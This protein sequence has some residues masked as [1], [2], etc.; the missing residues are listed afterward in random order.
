MTSLLLLTLACGGIEEIV[1]TDDQNFSFSSDIAA[2]SIPVPAQAD[3]PVDW[4]ALT[5]DLLGSA[6]EP[7]ADVGS[8]S[9][10]RFGEL[11]EE[12]VI[13]GINNESLKQSDLTGFVSYTPQGGE[14]DAMLSEFSVSG[15]FVDV[16]KEITVDGGTYL[17]SLE[18]Q[19]GSYMTFTFFDPTADA[20]DATIVVDDESAVL[21]YEADLDA[22]SA[23]VLP[24]AESYILTWS[25]LTTTASGNPIIL[26]NIDTL[27]LARYTAEVATLEADFLQLEALADELYVV[28]VAGLGSLD[29]ATVTDFGGFTGD[30]TWLVALRC[31]SCVNPSPPF[32]GLFA[33]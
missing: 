25:Q 23:I 13:D 18:D 5:M 19:A 30:G 21:S 6:V 14:T 24:K 27:M 8:V 20:P 4:S 1:L 26:S 28:D 7:S 31:G 12:E 32:L 9:I 22:G 17:I 11:T 15:T 3:S 29:L 10:V 33:P 2:A 16:D